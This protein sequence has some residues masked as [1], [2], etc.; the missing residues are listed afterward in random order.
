LVLPWL[1]SFYLLSLAGSAAIDTSV[2]CTFL[3]FGCFE[4]QVS[5]NLILQAIRRDGLVGGVTDHSDQATCQDL[6]L[7]G[8]A[9][10]ICCRTL[11]Q[12]IYANPNRN[13]I[14]RI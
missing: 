6:S 10:Y 2:F 4:G 12:D 13:A 8:I 9:G 1:L 11:I 3:T 14:R 5:K 7:T